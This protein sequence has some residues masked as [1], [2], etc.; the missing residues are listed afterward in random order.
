MNE[1][2][3][4][5]EGGCLCAKVRYQLTGDI[6]KIIHCHC[7][8]CRKWHGSAFR[9]RASVDASAF[10]WIAGKELVKEYESSDGITKTFCSHCGSSLVSFYAEHPDSVGIS[11]GTLDG[12][13]KKRPECHIFT[14]SKAPWYE[15]SDNLPQYE[16][17]PENPELLFKPGVD[18]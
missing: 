14:A 15:I 12:D 5:F 9:T 11:L 7:K 18:E 4:S 3:P 13:P 2:K 8:M 1:T 17:L 16:T 6:S 10:S